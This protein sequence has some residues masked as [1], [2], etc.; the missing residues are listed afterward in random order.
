MV[1]GAYLAVE[2]FTIR[3]MSDF[4]IFMFMVQVIADLIANVIA[5]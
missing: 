3:V 4:K 2:C 1:L 5:N